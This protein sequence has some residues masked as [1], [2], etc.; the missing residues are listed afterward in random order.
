MPKPG[1]FVT[2]AV[3]SL[4]TGLAAGGPAARAQEAGSLSYHVVQEGQVVVVECD[5]FGRLVSQPCPPASDSRLE[6][7]QKQAGG[8]QVMN[9][10][11]QV[12]TP[13]GWEYPPPRQ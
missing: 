5:Q 11:G 8:A 2:L 10:D 1:L 4:V 3:A 9:L 7:I 6:A 13:N 12:L